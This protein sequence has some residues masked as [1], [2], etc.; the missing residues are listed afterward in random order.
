MDDNSRQS[1]LINFRCSVIE[2][3]FYLNILSLVLEEEEEDNARAR[4]RTH[5]HARTHT[6]IYIYIML[7]C[8]TNTFMMY[9]ELCWKNRPWPTDELNT[10]ATPWRDWRIPQETFNDIRFLGWVLQSWIPQ[11]S[12]RC[13]LLLHLFSD[14]FTSNNERET[15]M[16]MNALQEI[17]HDKRPCRQFAP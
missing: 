7:H 12:V 1:L 3:L 4:A 11:C 15:G 6:H 5:A 17:C 9:W 16:T 2:S 10:P 14:A 13:L 8:V